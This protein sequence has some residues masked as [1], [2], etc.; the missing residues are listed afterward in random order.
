[1]GATLRCVLDPDGFASVPDGYQLVKTEL[2]L[3]QAFCGTR[4]IWVR[5]SQD[6]ITWAAKA[7]G[8]R[9]WIIETRSN[10]FESLLARHPGLAPHLDQLVQRAG[11]SVVSGSLVAL[12]R[13]VLKGVPTDGVGTAEHLLKFLLWNLETTLDAPA[14]TLRNALLSHWCDQLQG[15]ASESYLRVLEGEPT[16]HLISWFHVGPE[17]P[18]QRWLTPPAATAD[19]TAPLAKA[20]HTAVRDLLLSGNA[21]RIHAVLASDS[22]RTVKQIVVSAVLESLE[23]NASLFPVTQAFITLVS[24]FTNAAQADAFQRFLSPLVPTALPKDFSDLFSWYASIY[25]PYRRWAVL[26]D[27]VTARQQ[28]QKL[29]PEFTCWY[30]EQLRSAINGGP[31]E[32]YLAYRK[33]RKLWDLADESVVLLIVL[34]GLLPGDDHQVIQVVRGADPEWDIVVNDFAATLVPTITEYC[35]TSLLQGKPPIHSAAQT[36]EVR[37]RKDAIVATKQAVQAGKGLVV[38]V[39]NEPDWTYHSKSD[40]PD[41]TRYEV[42]KSV[43]SIATD[44]AS[45]VTGLPKEASVSIVLTSDHGRSLGASARTYLIPEGGK[46]HDRMVHMP[47]QYQQDGAFSVQDDGLVRIDEK[48]FGVGDGTSLIPGG[49]EAFSNK[50]G[51]EIWFVHGGA[52]PEETVVPWITLSRIA[53]EVRLVGSATL[54]GVAGKECDL[55]VSLSNPSSIDLLPVEAQ[56]QRADGTLLSIG[57][58]VPILKPLTTD[59]ISVSVLIGA[60]PV[61]SPEITL[62]VRKPSGELLTVVIPMEVSL[63]AMQDRE[64]DLMEDFDS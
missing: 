3:W 56:I 60:E 15:V 38:W 53:S 14:V 30:L 29:W 57:L 22:P 6:L 20:I 5:G 52:L 51:G 63:R 40:S 43:H 36:S 25:L 42:A 8:G 61:H 64:I 54:R 62:Q 45:L 21:S 27:D 23:Q 11:V 12:A 33:V 44:I 37:T 10:E 55:V 31:G 16:S 1:M 18:K 59:L 28:L 24:P 46:A 17:V 26:T 58:N 41:N 39:F 19:A 48:S 9:G 34:D 50:T 32:G 4:S 2:E 35:K 49:S 13:A 47:V 7:L